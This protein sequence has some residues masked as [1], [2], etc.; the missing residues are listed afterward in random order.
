MADKFRE[1]GTFDDSNLFRMLLLDIILNYS[2]FKLKDLPETSTVRIQIEFMF[3][4]YYNQYDQRFKDENDKV[5]DMNYIK[6][7]SPHIFEQ[8]PITDLGEMFG[9]DGLQKTLATKRK[10]VRKTQIF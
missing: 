4:Y 1:I 6:V 9:M 8:T 7:H 2:L 5:H 3:L 10:Y